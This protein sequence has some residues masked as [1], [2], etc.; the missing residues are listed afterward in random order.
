MHALL[1][2][3]LLRCVT[4]FTVLQATAAVAEPAAPKKLT[5]KEKA[6]ARALYDEGLRHYNVAEYA[7]AITASKKAYLPSGDPKLLFNVPQS[8]RLNGDREQALR[9]YRNFQREAPGAANQTEVDA[10]I[11]KCET[12]SPAPVAAAPPER[13]VEMA[14]PAPAP[15]V[16]PPP[17]SP[18]APPEV[19]LA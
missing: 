9:F 12:A 16:T 11:S 18:V 8:Y 6:E 1:R 13:A 17:T 19:P 7:Q 14:N 5:Q 10:A 3:R 15:T 2:T 4:V